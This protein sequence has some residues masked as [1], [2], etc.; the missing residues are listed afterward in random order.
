MKTESG[1]RGASGGCEAESRQLIPLEKLAYRAS[2]AVSV[3][4]QPAPAELGWRSGERKGAFSVEAVAEAEPGRIAALEE[5]LRGA[6]S[7]TAARIDGL[8][9]EGREAAE[10]A[11]REAEQGAQA[12]LERMARQVGAALESFGREREAYFARVEREVVELALAIAARILHREALLDPLLLAG[13]ARVA[14]GQLGETSG[15]RL[16]CPAA[17]E[18]RW[19]ELLDG[20]AP[21]P[22]IAGDPT[23]A[24]GECVLEAQVG[25][26]DLG[27][28]AQLAEIERGFF[29]LLEQRPGA[30]IRGGPR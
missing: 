21:M 14:L 1:D 16:R 26:V 15:V 9:R 20:L 29:D 24:A 12:T 13:A 28:R 6:E 11:R 10:Q 22:E 23:L 7:S 30:A 27:V 4:A 18:G 17:D 8:R 3:A 25:S 2:G 19:R 5:R